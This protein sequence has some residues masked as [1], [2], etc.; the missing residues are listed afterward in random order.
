[1]DKL[2]D[3]DEVKKLKYLSDRRRK[4][5]WFIY[6]FRAEFPIDAIFLFY[7][8]R[9]RLFPVSLQAY[10]PET[11]GGIGGT[12]VTV[13]TTLTKKQIIQAVRTISD[14]HRIEQTLEFVKLWVVV[15]P[16]TPVGA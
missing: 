9:Y 11:F 2:V 15:P 4:K 8:A 7:I 3:W 12:E 16:Q 1:M 14:A 5:R 13:Y 10:D 6:K